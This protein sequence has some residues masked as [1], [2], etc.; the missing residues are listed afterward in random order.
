MNHCYLY[1][2]YANHPPEPSISVNLPPYPY[3]QHLLDQL[4]IYIGHDYHWF[5]L[6]SFKERVEIT[7]RNPGSSESKD[8][9]WLCQLLI[10]FSLGETFV[11][12]HAPVIHLGSTAEIGR[13]AELEG[14]HAA[15]T[16]PGAAFFEQALALLRLPYEEPS[17]EHVE[18]LNL[19]VS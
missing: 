6:R 17:I 10:V 15:A 12:W 11:N 13:N 2:L 1:R 9:F 3:A 4:E 8:R 19:A 14:G 16:A 7:Y 18:T 5:L